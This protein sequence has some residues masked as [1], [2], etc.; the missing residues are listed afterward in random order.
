MSTLNNLILCRR[1]AQ[2]MINERNLELAPDFFAE[3]SVHHEIGEK[4]PGVHR[5]PQAMAMFLDLYLRAFPDLRIGFEDAMANGDQVVTRW[6]F[7][8]TQDGPLMSMPASGRR[9]SVEGIR[10]DRIEEGK[11]AESWMQMDQ[12]ALLEQIGALPVV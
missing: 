6:R 7:E 3:G 2:R 12:L 10:I 8:G 9:V 1:F 11:I 4:R 5:G